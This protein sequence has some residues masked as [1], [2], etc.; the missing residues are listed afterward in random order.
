MKEQ[1]RTACSNPRPSRTLSRP[2]RNRCTEGRVSGHGGGGSDAAGLAGVFASTATALLGAIATIRFSV[3]RRRR[4]LHAMAE[5]ER[6]IESKVAI[7]RQAAENLHRLGWQ[8]SKQIDQLESSDT[9]EVDASDQSS[10]EVDRSL[11]AKLPE[12]GSIIVS[13]KQAA[14]ERKVNQLRI[15]R[16]NEDILQA[17]YTELANVRGGRNLNQIG[18]LFRHARIAFYSFLGIT[19]TS[20]AILLYGAYLAIYGHI[21][22]GVIVALSS[23]VPGGFSAGLYRISRSA[24]R[25]SENALTMLNRE[26]ERDTQIGRI[27]NAT[28]TI[29]DLET[30]EAIQTLSALK[31]AFPDASPQELS[32]LLSAVRTNAP[33]GSNFIERQDEGS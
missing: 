32:S 6:L 31:A 5:V 1:V 28:Q 20:S 11:P 18:S 25:Q 3:W 19:M 2:G 33:R 23:A 26:V 29:S 15:V 13:P 14:I 27:V 16:G 4:P 7:Q 10:T 8:I 21:A 12:A 17:S 22:S 30:Q 9:S 24:D